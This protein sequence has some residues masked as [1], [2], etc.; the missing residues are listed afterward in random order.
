MITRS[1]SKLAAAAA[2]APSEQPF[3]FLDLPEELR[4]MVYENLMDKMHCKVK[5]KTPR[6]LKVE[7]VYLDDMYYPGILQ[8]SKL[9]R[10][11][12]WPLCLR[13]TNLWI[14]YTCADPEDEGEDDEEEEGPTMPSIADWV[15][16]PDEVLDKITEVIFKFEADWDLPKIGKWFIV[17]P[18]P[19]FD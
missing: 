18:Q 10:D 2:D 19:V 6:N 3:R 17:F 11:E 13:T 7:Q 5:F 1:Q 4:L 12:Y 16:I 8:V 15:E 9:V 14:M